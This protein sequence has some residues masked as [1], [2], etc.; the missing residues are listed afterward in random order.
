M[1]SQWE[2]SGYKDMQ[3]NNLSDQIE[4]ERTDSEWLLDAL[5]KSYHMTESAKPKQNILLPVLLFAMLLGTFIYYG[6]MVKK[7]ENYGAESMNLGLT[8]KEAL[9]VR[10]HKKCVLLNPNQPECCSRN[11]TDKT[12]GIYGCE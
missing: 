3:S 5:T 12:K 11:L 9:I 8:V 10:E 4:R 1:S 2:K 7:G 6:E